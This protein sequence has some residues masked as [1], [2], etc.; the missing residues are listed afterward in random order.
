MLSFEYL[1]P[2][3]TYLLKDWERYDV[4]RYTDIGCVSLEE[5]RRT[6]PVSEHE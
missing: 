6:F 2:T 1:Y 5:G 4:S 3:S